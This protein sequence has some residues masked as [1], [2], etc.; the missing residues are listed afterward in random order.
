MKAKSDPYIIVR[1]CPEGPSQSK[2]G[3]IFMGQTPTK[4]KTLAPTWRNQSF[5][6]TLPK[7]KLTEHSIVELTIMDYDEDN[8][9]DLMGVVPVPIGTPGI[10]TNWYD[11]PSESA[12]G[13][14][15]T[16]KVECVMNV[17][18]RILQEK[19]G[20]PKPSIAEPAPAPAQAQ[21][22][23]P[24]I[25]EERGGDSFKTL[26]RTGDQSTNESP[27]TTQDLDATA[28]SPKELEETDAD[29]VVDSK[30]FPSGVDDDGDY[31]WLQEAAQ[32]NLGISGS[33]HV[34][35]ARRRRSTIRDIDGIGGSEYLYG[36]RR[37]SVRANDGD[38]CD[39]ERSRSRR[40]SVRARSKDMDY[41][42]HSRGRRTSLRSQSA[43]TSSRD[44]SSRR[45]RSSL[46]V[47]GPGLQRTATT[48]GMQKSPRGEESRRSRR[49]SAMPLLSTS[50]ALKE[51]E[52]SDR[53]PLRDTRQ[54][55]SGGK[56]SDEEM[57]LKRSMRR[58][59]SKP[60]RRS[61]T[62]PIEELSDL[63]VDDNSI[64]RRSSEGKKREESHRFNSK[65]SEDPGR[66][67]STSSK[68]RTS[69]MEKQNPASSGEEER[70]ES[71]QTSRKPSSKSRKS[72]KQVGRKSIRRTQS[73]VEHTVSASL[74]EKVPRKEKD[75][76]SESPRSVQ[77][78]IDSEDMQDQRK[79]VCAI[80]DQWASLKQERTSLDKETTQRLM[81]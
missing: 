79:K 30:S 75:E 49:A 62:L 57:E 22:A 20:A 39:G 53:K 21:A 4:F 16:G 12:G 44:H 15:A 67:R 8:E 6:A 10:T 81:L 59:S 36:R 66:A 60:I 2:E 35:S 38:S 42:D 54:A 13:E 31:R 64:K 19:S 17:T 33:E 69:K 9:D 46:R 45:T 68:R 70:A 23:V 47:S 14:E 51:R 63:L 24:A 73:A 55:V 1:L 48:G 77:Q 72:I 50:R 5:S 52:E 11:V 32:R 37:A 25:A 61:K 3:K 56:K 27:L 7:G 65:K 26:E 76:R 41:R 71:K 34:P 78:K 28:V 43:D 80:Y 18:N 40:A 74:A 58:K 29:Q